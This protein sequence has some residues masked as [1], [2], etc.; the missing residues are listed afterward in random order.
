MKARNVLII[1]FL[2]LATASVSAQ[3]LE[4][5]G[6]RLDLGLSYLATGG[7]SDTSSFGFSMGTE[8]LVDRWRF[9][10]GAEA[11][12]AEEESEKTAERFAAFSRAAWSI[13][14][15]LALTTGWQGEQNRFAGIDHRS[16]VDLG[17]SWKAIQRETWTVETV[18]AATWNYE[19]PV[20]GESGSNAGLLLM[21]RSHYQISENA[22][23][24]QMLRL[25][26]NI[27]DVDDFRLDARVGLTA[28]ITDIIGVK[29]SYEAR[30]DAQPVPGFEST[31]TMAT[32]SLVMNIRREEA[33]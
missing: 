5:D 25:E 28:S 15:R 26:P 16:T 24:S 18:S 32:V 27:E 29:L 21:G 8:K 30:Y 23:T 9:L 1:F 13:S 33:E 31:D 6:W 2:S 14:E 11:L 3:D 10:A 22:S 7:N 19:D 20:L 4:G 12:Q 17:V